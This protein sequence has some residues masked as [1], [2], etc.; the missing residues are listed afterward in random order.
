MLSALRSILV[1]TMLVAGPPQVF[2]ETL[3]GVTFDGFLITVDTAT[4]AGTMVAS[5]GCC[6]SDI[7]VRSGVLYVYVQPSNLLKEITPQGTVL[8]AI[9]I[10]T[11]VPAEGG[12]AFRSDGRGFVNSDGGGPLYVFDLS[13]PAAS[14]VTSSFAFVDG[15]AF[16]RQGR[17]YGTG[18]ARVLYSVDQNTGVT[19]TIGPLGIA[20]VS[21]VRALAFGADGPLFG[22]I[23]DNLYTIDVTTGSAKLV[24][25]I[26]FGLVSGIVSITPPTPQGAIGGLI[27]DVQ[28]LLQ[29]GILTADQA[30]GLIDKLTA[31]IS[32]L[33]A[34]NL[35]STCGQM[36][37]FVN[38]VNAFMR[39][40]IVTFVQGQ[41][42]LRIADAVSAEIGCV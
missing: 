6:T 2:A 1:L 32:G 21:R 5:L 42:L 33:N 12:L 8:N 37:A 36:K 22:P 41:A 39:S 20:P 23:N 17:L 26:G 40:G 18:S 13:I 28:G 30:N 31:A 9:N 19:T 4:G 34:G 7:G 27:Q 24:G 3:F 29:A 16:D 14:I 35:R 25:P 38:Q 15:L 10:G 11:D